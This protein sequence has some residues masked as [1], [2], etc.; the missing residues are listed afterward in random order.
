VTTLEDLN[1]IAEHQS[2]SIIGKVTSLFPVE[3]VTIKA[4]ENKLR[5]RDL[6]LSDLTAVYRYVAWE[7]E[8][9]VL[10][11]SKSYK[12]TNATIRT[13]NGEKYISIGQK[14]KIAII[15]DIGEVIDNESPQGSSGRAK[16][17]TSDIISVAKVDEYKSCYNCTA[18]LSNSDTPLIVCQKFNA[19]MKV[20]RCPSQRMA[21]ITLENDSKKAYHVT[22]F[23]DVLEKVR[24]LGKQ[25]VGDVDIYDQLLSA[26]P[27]IYTINQK[28]IVSSVSIVNT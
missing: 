11:E 19:K 24:N 5:K 28:D 27:L 21:D 9:D 6:F 14:S 13:F 25:V 3:K 10:Q 17:V 2:I 16:V 7:S 18:K 12:I 1:N 23:N 8:I 26:P 20:T 4:T 22:I 15:E